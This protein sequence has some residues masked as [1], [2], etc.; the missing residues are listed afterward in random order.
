MI[1]C[2]GSQPIPVPASLIEELV[3]AMQAIGNED[4]AITQKFANLYAKYKGNAE[5]VAYQRWWSSLS[6]SP[7]YQAAFNAGWKAGLSDPVLV[8][9]AP[10]NKYDPP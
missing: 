3:L 5:A 4:L 1:A 9:S 7:S 6:S 2:P 10:V 8:H